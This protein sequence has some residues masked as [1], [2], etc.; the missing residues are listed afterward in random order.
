[1]DKKT[2]DFSA[3]EVQ[4]GDSPPHPFSY[5]NKTVDVGDEGQLT[6]WMTHTNEA[7]HGLV[8]ESD[9]L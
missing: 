9:D 6:C 8:L 3:L 5:L 1:L 2:I 4:K 7:A